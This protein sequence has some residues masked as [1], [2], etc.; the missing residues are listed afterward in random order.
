MEELP[1]DINTTLINNINDITDLQNLLTLNKYYYTNSIEKYKKN[2]KDEKEFGLYLTYPLYV[3]N[4]FGDKLDKLLS[5]PTL[6]FK[7]HF[8]HGFTGYIDGIGENDV[9]HPIMKGTDTCGRQFITFKFKFKE[10]ENIE[11]YAVSTLF[12]RY[13]NYDSQTWVFGTSSIHLHENTCPSLEDIENYK[14]VINGETVETDRYFVR[15]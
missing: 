11:R 12:K 14:K 10:K 3:L 2:E 5:C 15:L 9:S 4:I 7:P 13:T 8:L 1:D 6:D